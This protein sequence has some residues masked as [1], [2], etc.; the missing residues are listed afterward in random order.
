MIK[1]RFFFEE[2]DNLL[3]VIYKNV[4]VTLNQER[5]LLIIIMIIIIM[6]MM[7]MKGGTVMA[8]VDLHWNT[9]PPPSPGGTDDNGS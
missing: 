5:Q 7:I 2:V 9:I 4:I 6:I 1:L 8:R 3:F